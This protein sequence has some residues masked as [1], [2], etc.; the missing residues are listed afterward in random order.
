[1]SAYVHNWT[2]I[3]AQARALIRESSA[4]FWTDATLL[5]YANEGIKAIAWRVGGYRTFTTVSTTALTRLVSF[6]GY[7]CLAVEYDEKALIKI[8]PLQL[9]HVPLDGIY[10][11]YWFEFGNYI[12]IEPVPPEVYTLTVYLASIPTDMT[13]G[14]SVPSVPYAFCGM[15]T[16]YIAARALE[17]D[18]RFD[19]SAQLMDIFNNDLDFLSMALLPNIPNGIEDVRF[20]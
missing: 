5:V 16:Y 3:M 7:K 20:R 19:A 10:P 6:T 8:T 1:M 13:T 18:R 17:Q 14:A 4:S 2:A 9:G 11:Q 12:G 15:L